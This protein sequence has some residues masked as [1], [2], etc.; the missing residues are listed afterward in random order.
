MLAL[1]LFSAEKGDACTTPDRPPKV[2]IRAELDFPEPTKEMGLGSVQFSVRVTVDQNGRVT[3]V[4]IEKSSTNEKLDASAL[5][6]ARQ[7]KYAPAIKNCAA[8]PGVVIS[9]LPLPRP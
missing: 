1:A 8:V 3:G 5:R 9:L 6:A 7:S 4:S 2:L